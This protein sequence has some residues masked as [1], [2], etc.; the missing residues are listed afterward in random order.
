VHGWTRADFLFGLGKMH[1][2][3]IY[4]ALFAPQFIEV[5]GFVMLGEF[6]VLPRGGLEEVQ[7]QIRNARAKSSG[8]VARFVDSCNWV[9]VPYLMS[10]N[11]SS[12]AE[13]SVLA[14]AIADAWQARLNGLF[15]SRTFHVQVLAKEETGSVVGVGFRE[16]KS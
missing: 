4:S 16:R 14:H 8:D 7:R 5:E 10:D 2:A 9:E 15:P 12:D 6:G 11:R 1:D 3:L 13:D